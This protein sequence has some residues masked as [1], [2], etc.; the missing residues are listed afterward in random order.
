MLRAQVESGG[1]VSHGQKSKLKKMKEKYVDQDEE[2]RK[3][4]MN[5]L[6]E[7]KFTLSKQFGLGITYMKVWPGWSGRL[8]KFLPRWLDFG[9]FINPIFI[10]AFGLTLIEVAA[11]GL[12][13]VAQRIMD[14]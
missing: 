13:M 9:C 10:E 4:Q 2:E 7:S 14:L 1:K 11:Y 5:L 3:I 6:A 8:V 12:P